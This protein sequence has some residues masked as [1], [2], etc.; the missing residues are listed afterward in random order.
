MLGDSA[1]PP[2][3][4]KDGGRSHDDRFMFPDRPVAITIPGL[5]RL[6]GDRP[7]DLPCPIFSPDDLSPH[8][9]PCLHPLFRH[10]E[11]ATLVG[12]PKGGVF[13]KW[14]FPFA[15]PQTEPTR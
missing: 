2:L 10:P 4:S 9:H 14:D 13:K 6:C 11:K 12:L 8:A 15:V 7:F 1:G 5:G 3:S